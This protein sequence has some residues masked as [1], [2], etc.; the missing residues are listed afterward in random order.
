MSRGDEIV[1][2][3]RGCVGSVVESVEWD[4]YDSGLIEVRTGTHVVRAC[5]SHV[6]AEAMGLGENLKQGTVVAEDGE[7]TQR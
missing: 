3:L 5:V 4:G 2:V 1:E 7:L 6:D